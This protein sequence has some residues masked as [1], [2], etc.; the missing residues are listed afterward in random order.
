MNKF[1]LLVLALS[2]CF[3]KMAAQCVPQ[4]LNCNEAV[5]ACDLSNNNPQYWNEL[6]WWDNQ[7]Q[8]HDL[9]ETKINLNIAVKDTCPGSSLSV[10]CLL[11]LDLDGD[12]LFE[13]VVDSDNPPAA[14]TVN[15]NNAANPNYSGGTPRNF[16]ERPVP[17]N[18]KWRFILKTTSVGDSSNISL[19]WINDAAPNVFELP[20]LAYG[21]HKVR[22]IV[23]DL[24]GQIKT[25]EKS[26]RVK[27][28]NPPTVVC[29]NG[30]SVNIMPTQ[31]ITLWA[32][33]FLQFAEDNVSPSPLIKIGI[34]K[35]GTGTGFPVDVFG[36]PITNV[37]FNCD[38]LDTQ[39]VELWAIDTEGNADYC[40]TNILVQ[41]NLG[42]CNGS[43]AIT[44]CAKTACG[45]GIE[46]ASFFLG[47]TSPFTPPFWFGFSDANS[48]STIPG[49]IPIA[50]GFIV[51]AEKEDSPLEGVSQFDLITIQ[52]HID[53]IDLFDSPYQWMAADANRD[54]VIDTLDITECRKLILGFPT[55]VLSWRFVDKTY[56]F[57][58]PNPLSQ[59]IPE[60]ITLNLSTMPITVEFIGVKTCDLNCGNLVG[61][62][63]L[64]PENEHLIGVP[65]PNPT[66]EGTLLPLQLLRA[67]FVVLELADFSG[68]LMFH[69]EMQLPAGPALLEIPAGVMPQAGV[70]V[71]RVWAGEETKAGKLIRY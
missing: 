41:D 10:R 55:N 12:G 18:Q 13:T 53:G 4:L 16:D 23:T 6:Y 30:L 25:C 28:C 49:L 47:G 37:T 64:G 62:F 39:S 42:N 60:T 61:F 52:K 27:D 51:S 15:F 71:W 11:F 17:A 48:C 54:N 3:S 14:G 58:T 70:Y 59:P 8:S 50:D 31:M 36:N 57:P 66:N 40:E 34:R 69:T 46:A 32:T 20:E 2:P 63:D 19:Q 24:A 56:V 38:E 33:D 22:W 35:P 1:L 43:H 5:Q 45:E 9:A 7:N 65:Q 44:I 26:F 21:F 68:K 67:E 29:L